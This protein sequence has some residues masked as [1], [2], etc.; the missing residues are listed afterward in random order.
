MKTKCLLVFG[1]ALMAGVATPLALFAF[2]DRA[3]RI[4][5]IQKARPS[6]KSESQR[7]R[8]HL[9]P[10]FDR[11]QKII[12]VVYV[13]HGHGGNLENMFHVWKSP[14]EQLGI[15]LIALQGS[16]ELSAG[17][18]AWSGPEDALQMIRVTRKE[19]K[20]VAPRISRF[21]PRVLTGISQGAFATY[22]IARQYP[23]TYRR[24]IPVVGMFRTGT[25]HWAM[26]LDEDLCK[27]VA[28]WRVYMMVGVK[29]KQELVSDN[30]WLESELRRC[31][32]KVRAPF[33]DRKDPSWSMYQDTGHAFPAQGEALTAELIRGLQFVLEPNTK[34]TLHWSHEDPAWRE[35][36]KWIGKS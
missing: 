31:G 36:A 16:K 18:Y 29:D 10:D 12:P 23:T 14:C 2:Q 30:H 7:M 5:S 32:A 19:L 6:D 11:D 17:S 13:F 26:S 20:K 9:P 22:A 8:I 25:H 28:H 21:A 24:L 34:D 27:A 4:K 35:K 3:P 1:A 33:L 15:V